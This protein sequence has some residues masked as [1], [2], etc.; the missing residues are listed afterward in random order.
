MQTPRRGFLKGLA[1]APLAPAALAPQAPPVPVPAPAP[2]PSAAPSPPTGHEAV[3]EALAE[4]VK[5]E[6]GAHL[7]PAEIEAVRK[8]LQNGLERA[9]RLRQAARLSNADEPVNRFEA[10]PAGAPAR[11][12]RR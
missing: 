1:V 7:D 10:R 8:E 5:R 12:E 11:G 6:F 4:A 2:P 3:A 9:E